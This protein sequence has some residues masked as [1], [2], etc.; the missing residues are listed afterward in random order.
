LLQKLIYFY[1]FMTTELFINKDV[2][3]TDEVL[4]DQCIFKCKK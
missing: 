3:N 4:H 2:S 1:E